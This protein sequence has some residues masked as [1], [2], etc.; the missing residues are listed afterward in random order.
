MND[1][2]RALAPFLARD[3]RLVF[4]L[5][6]ASG[7]VRHL[8][9][10]LADLGYP[11]PGPG[12]SSPGSPPPPRRPEDEV[13][14]SA[15]VG[16]VEAHAGL[17]GAGATETDDHDPPPPPFGHLA[18]LREFPAPS[19]DV[20]VILEQRHGRLRVRGGTIRFRVTAS[21]RLISLSNHLRPGLHR[22][23][24]TPRLT[25]EEAVAAARKRLPSLTQPVCPPELLVYPQSGSLRSGGEGPPLADQGPRLTG[26]RLR[27]AWEIHLQGLTRGAHGSY[28]RWVTF[29]DALDGEVFHFYDNVQTES[30]LGSGVGYYSGPGP[31]NTTRQGETYEL[32]DTTRVDSG[33]PVIMTHD[34]DGTYPSS[35][36]D[37]TWD[38][39]STLPRDQNQGTEADCHRFLAQ[40]V[41]YFGRVHGWQSYDGLASD[42]EIVAHYN[43]D[44][45]NAKWD[46]DFHVICIGDSDTVKYD[47]FGTDDVV[48][49]EFTHGCIQFNFNPEYLRESGALNEAAADAMAAFITGDWLMGEDLWLPDTSPA[50]RNVPNP[51]NGGQWDNTSEEAAIASADAGHYPDH[52]EDRFQG[53]YDNYGVHFNSTIVSHALYLLT[54]GGTHARSGIRVEGVG[55]AAVET[56]LW[57]TVS[58]KLIGNPQADFVDF[59]EAFTDACLDLYPTDVNLLAQ[60]KAAFTAVGVGPDLYVRDSLRDDGQEPY[61]GR[62]LY[63]SPDIINRTSPVADPVRDLGDMG[64]GNLGENVLA[65]KD[66]YVYIRLQ[67]RGSCPDDAVIQLYF[68]EATT[69]G[70]PSA[71]KAVGSAAKVAVVPGKVS[72]AGPIVFPAKLIPGVGHY[73]LIAVVAS[74]LDPAPDTSL[75]ADHETYLSYVAGSNNIAFRNLDVVKD[76]A[77]GGRVTVVAR[78][79]GRP[80]R[81]G[82]EDR[83]PERAGPEPAAVTEVYDLEILVAA[84]APRVV[85]RVRGPAGSLAKARA[86]PGLAR[87]GADGGE[88]VYEVVGPQGGRFEDLPLS[89]PVRLTVEWTATGPVHPSGPASPGKPGGSPDPTGLPYPKPFVQLR[90]SWRGR[91]LGAFGLTRA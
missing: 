84:G 14:R 66:N 51:T 38:D 60:A 56:A 46:G 90:Q 31:L 19:G 12:P 49:H 79:L 65:G 29:V 68:T 43:L 27:L 58:R 44:Y 72:V 33:G 32:R 50:M 7:A 2:I 52:Y 74:S 4:R 8:R 48:A 71:W 40:A 24:L 73:C 55:Q 3:P 42:A 21:G 86:T 13:L 10:D 20:E 47:Y 77:A 1:K 53:D 70:V 28:S 9:G 22:L 39:L 18:V 78:G 35:D 62:E 64:R 6:H 67:N 83:E 57:D 88:D 34:E 69:F 36:P 75:I 30:N 54:E 81:A 91:V 26:E 87:R 25:A 89:E 63:A 45:P 16:F 37:N 82:P 17:L 23:P 41:D 5:D 15:L 85:F 59:R 80:E 61:T 76:P 11:E